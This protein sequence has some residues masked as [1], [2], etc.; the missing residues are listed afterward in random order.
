MNDYNPIHREQ[1][2]LRAPSAGRVTL[3]AFVR[4]PP[5]FDAGF[6]PDTL[7]RDARA[8]IE[9]AITPARIEVVGHAS[10]NVRLGAAAVEP[11]AARLPGRVPEPV[12]ANGPTPEPAAQGSSTP[13]SSTACRCPE[14]SLPEGGGAGLALL[15][16]RKRD[17][18]LVILRRA[19]LVLDLH[20][21]RGL[22][23][24]QRFIDA[25]PPCASP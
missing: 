17:R 13:G 11:S 5:C 16:Q 18:D 2:S 8:P 22:A 23:R 1:L 12:A 6:A 21:A 14:G 24:R 9:V 10:P 4:R 3:G 25:L 20:V 19:Q 7:R 15:R